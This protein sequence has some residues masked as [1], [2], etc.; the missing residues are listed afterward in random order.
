LQ[1]N[2]MAF[3]DL[4]QRFLPPASLPHGL[5]EESEELLAEQAP[6]GK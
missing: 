3:S 4:W 2:L 1:F 5:A 6:A